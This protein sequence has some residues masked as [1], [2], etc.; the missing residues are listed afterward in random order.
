MWADTPI[1][2]WIDRCVGVCTGMCVDMWIDMWILNVGHVYRRVPRPHMPRLAEQPSIPLVVRHVWTCMLDKFR[3]V[4]AH[5]A[6]TAPT[7]AQA[8]A[9]GCMPY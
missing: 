5:V 2:M 8:H 4:F 9:T 3:H 7:R 1:D 6:A